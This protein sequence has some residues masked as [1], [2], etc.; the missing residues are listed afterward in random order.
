MLQGK[1]TFT[2]YTKKDNK[3]K[4]GKKTVLTVDLTNCPEDTAVALASQALVVKLQGSWR[5]KGI[6]ETATV[7][8][9]DHAPGTRHQMTPEE[10][11]ASLTPEQRAELVKK[12]STK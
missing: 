2:V 10:A 5:N 7:A 3:E 12:Y 8:M 9:K 11:F 4:V 1:R 6:P